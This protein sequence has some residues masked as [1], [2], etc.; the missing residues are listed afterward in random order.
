[1]KVSIL[2]YITRATIFVFFPFPFFFPISVGV[3]LLNMF[4]L[5]L[6]QLL[7]GFSYGGKVS[8]VGF[9]FFSIIWGSAVG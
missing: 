8:F 4:S 2:I 6:V 5:I 7:D 3:M 1:V 9:F